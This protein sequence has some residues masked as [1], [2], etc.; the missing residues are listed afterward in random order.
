MI[1]AIWYPS[2]GFGHFIN[3]VLTLHGENFIRPKKKL[4]FS[5]NGNSHNLDLVV[6]KYK[7]H[8]WNNNVEFRDDKNY[9]IL[10]DNGIDDE[11]D[12]FKSNIPESTIIKI[13]YSDYSWPIVALTMIEKAQCKDINQELSTDN[14]DSNSCWAQREKYFL[15]L[16]DHNFRHRWRKDCYQSITID[17][18]IVS[19]DRFFNALNLIT[20]IESCDELWNNWYHANHKYIFPVIEAQSVINCVLNKQSVDLTHIRDTWAQSVIYYYIWLY[21]GVEVPHNDFSNFFSDTR[22]IMDLVK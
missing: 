15:Y 1:Y 10:I 22:Q 7:Y 9:C 8:Q 6:P 13:C 14:W 11:L 21:F 17:E 20:K 5:K 3:A 19:Y 18:L 4:K 2:G 12:S 16:R